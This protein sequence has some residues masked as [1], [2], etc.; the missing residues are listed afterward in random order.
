MVQGIAS[1]PNCILVFSFHFG[2][3]ETLARGIPSSVPGENEETKIGELVNED[4][5]GVVV[6]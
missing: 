4:V 5:V 3:H 6:L 2:G 1:Q